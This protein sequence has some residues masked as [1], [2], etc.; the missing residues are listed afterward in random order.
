MI[1]PPEQSS[2]I[3]TFSKND[4]DNTRTVLH[5]FLTGYYEF[6]ENTTNLTYRNCINRGNEVE[7]FKISIDDDTVITLSSG[8]SVLRGVVIHFL[9][10]SVID[11]SDI[12]NYL[13][14]D[15]GFDQLNVDDSIYLLIYYNPT[16]EED[17]EAVV[18]FSTDPMLFMEDIESGYAICLGKLSVEI[19]KSTAML[20]SVTGYDFESDIFP[21][22][23]GMFNF[24]DG[25][26]VGQ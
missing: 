20:I 2:Y 16:S 21:I 15:D 23:P 17:N 18:G 10:D 22:R 9:E 19:D 11:A 26:I 8:I 25:G 14:D 7:S 5:N 13:Y 4:N 6:L 12:A 24:I 3:D 1:Q